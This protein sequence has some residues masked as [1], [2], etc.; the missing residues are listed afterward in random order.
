MRLGVAQARRAWIGADQV[1]NARAWRDV[2]EADE[3]AVSDFRGDGRA[4]LDWV[5]EYLERVGELPVASSVSP[6]EVRARF[7]PR[8][9][10]A[11]S[12]SRPFSTTSTT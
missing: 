1:V 5:A 8:R 7:P 3:E 11:A 6:G 2:H 4:A 9:L 10:S 12:P